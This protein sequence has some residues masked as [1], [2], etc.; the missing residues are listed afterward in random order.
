MLLMIIRGIS[1]IF[2]PGS[3]SLIHL[4]QIGDMHQILKTRKSL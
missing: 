1:A 2:F 4:L 3:S